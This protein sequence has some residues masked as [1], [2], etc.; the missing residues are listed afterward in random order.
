ERRRK[1]Q[2]RES[3]RQASNETAA[4]NH[5]KSC[6]GPSHQ[7]TNAPERVCS[8]SSVC[9]TTWPRLAPAWTA[10]AREVTHVAS[11]SRWVCSRKKANQCWEKHSAKERLAATASSSSMRL[12]YSPSS[13]ECDCT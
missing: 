5:W 4:R 6:H 8:S 7:G 10:S 13:S 12:A 2:P 1:G 11:R 3:E 9:S